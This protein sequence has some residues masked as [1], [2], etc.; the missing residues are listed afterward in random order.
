MKKI[1]LPKSNGAVEVTK[2]SPP[3]PPPP[4]PPADEPLPPPPP[5]MNAPVGPPPQA[6]ELPTDYEGYVDLAKRVSRG[7]M[8]DKALIWVGLAQAQATY[9]VAGLLAELVDA[10]HVLA[11]EK[12]KTPK[13]KLKE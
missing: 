13:S 7:S 6:V 5:Q 11:V 1:M 2:F 12:K 4:A 3:T 9:E 8:T 10:L